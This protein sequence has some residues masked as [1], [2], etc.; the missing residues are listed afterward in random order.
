MHYQ[1]ILCPIDFSD[2]S[3]VAA[4][5]AVDLARSA[6]AEIVLVHALDVVALTPETSRPPDRGLVEKLDAVLADVTDVTVSRFFHPGPPVE[7]ICWAAQD[8][9]C[10]LIV[11]GTHGRTGLKHLL[12]G[13]VAEHVLRHAPV[14]IL[15]V[16]DRPADERPLVE[17]SVDPVLAPR[18]E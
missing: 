14:P 10:D 3:Q 12:M 11:I 6:G 16:R 1:R 17:P 7:V 2:C 18:Y 4:R 8:R 5:Y 13:S 15:V 9:G